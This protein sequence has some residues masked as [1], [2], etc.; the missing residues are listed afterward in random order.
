M[1]E[2]L[3]A[4][5]ISPGRRERRSGIVGTVSGPGLSISRPCEGP[6][7]FAKHEGNPYVRLLSCPSPLRDEAQPFAFRGHAQR[8]LGE[9]LRAQLRSPGRPP[10]VPGEVWLRSQRQ[11]PRDARTAPPR[12]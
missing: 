3:S 5:P 11:E 6:T 10:T 2:G 4:G 12:V 9:S 8:T 7:F 1:A